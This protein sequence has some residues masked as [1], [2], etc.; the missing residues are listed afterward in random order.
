[1]S[2][3][4]HI[5]KAPDV[6]HKA[7]LP[8]D[9]D[10]A[11]KAS[12]PGADPV[13]SAELPAP[14]QGADPAEPSSGHADPPEPSSGHA[15]IP[16]A[17]GV[18]AANALA[19]REREPERDEYPD[20]MPLSALAPRVERGPRAP[21][22][23]HAIQWEIVRCS[24]CGAVAGQVKLDPGPGGR[25]GPTWNMRVKLSNG[26]WAE[27]A[28]L[29]RKR[30]VSV[31]GET[32]AKANGMGPVEQEVLQ[33]T[34]Y[35]WRKKLHAKSLMQHGS[36]HCVRYFFHVWF[37]VLHAH[38]SGLSMAILLARSVLQC[39]SA[40]LSQECLYRAR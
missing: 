3:S 27:K 1:M 16:I 8:G 21:Q 18:P 39:C 14:P 15:D 2:D 35:A 40:I 26:Q 23:A 25:D 6:E 38:C 13:D 9:G 17:D 20:D 24:H 33:L 22:R 29:F 12:P 32:D 7:N 31:F 19:I 37:A 30:R 28:P 4:H 10:G 5:F 36:W 11:E 34:S